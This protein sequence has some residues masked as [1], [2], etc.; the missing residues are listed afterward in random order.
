MPEWMR[1]EQR[2]RSV[3]EYLNAPDKKVPTAGDADSR[4]WA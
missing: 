1:E 4:P 3:A 2:L